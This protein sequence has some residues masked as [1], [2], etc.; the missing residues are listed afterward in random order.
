MGQ[1]EQVQPSYYNYP[2]HQP[3]DYLHLQPLTPITPCL[4]PQPPVPQY[5]TSVT[6]CLSP[7][8]PVPQYLASGSPSFFLP[9]NP[10]SSSTLATL[11]GTSF[12]SQDTAV[13]DQQVPPPSRPPTP[14]RQRN[15]EMF[16]SPFK[17]F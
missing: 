13:E 16:K 12:P 14:A 10:S 4:S 5:L 2:V 1:P 17:R 8:P 9:P 6:P 3:T 7:Q 15:V 11:S